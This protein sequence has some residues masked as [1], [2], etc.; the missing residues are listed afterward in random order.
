ML[1][2]AQEDVDAWWTRLEFLLEKSAAYSRMLKKRMDLALDRKRQ[3]D[4]EALEL[5]DQR[6]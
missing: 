2:A 1:T 4:K 5:D 6:A 3:P